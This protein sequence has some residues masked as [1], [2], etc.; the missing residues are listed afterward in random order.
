MK[1]FENVWLLREWFLACQA[2]LAKVE[3][4]LSKKS[5]QYYPVVH[6]K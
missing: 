6:T 4:K 3:N 1:L 2:V 5:D